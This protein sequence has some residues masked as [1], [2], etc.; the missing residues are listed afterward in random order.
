M[1]YVPVLSSFLVADP[2]EPNAMPWL[3]IA[4]REVATG[5]DCGVHVAPPSTA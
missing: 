3:L 1:R 4:E 2:T 5:V